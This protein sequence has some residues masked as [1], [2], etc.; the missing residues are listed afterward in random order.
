MTGSRH[1]DDDG[2][3]VAPPLDAA[4]AERHQHDERGQV[5]RRVPGHSPASSFRLAR[6]DSAW[7]GVIPL[8]SSA[9]SRRRIASSSSGGASKRPSCGCRSA[10]LPL[11]DG[12]PPRD[13]SSRSSPFRISRARDDD[14]GRQAG[15]PR[16]LD[17]VAAVRSARDD[18][19]QEHDVVFPLAD[20]DVE[21]GHRGQRVGEIGQLVV[22]RREDGL[23]PRRGCST[24]GA[25]RP[26]RRG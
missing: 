8:M 18:L 22:V 1:P 21:V 2:V 11:S 24:P 14:V 23:G 10:P 17:A 12:R 15:Q 4:R 25:R 13:S 5:P 7:S 26:P 6:S 3:A 20:D 9:R 16:H 19:A